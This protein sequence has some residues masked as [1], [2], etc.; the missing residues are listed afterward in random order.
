MHV[1]SLKVHLCNIRGLHSNLDPVHYHLETEKPHL[2]FLT[3]TQIRCPSD[4]A[5]LNYPNY[6]LEHNFRQR[7]GVCVY[8]RNDICCRRLRNL[9]DPDFSVL[10]ILVDTGIEQILYCG[11]YRSHSG[12][13]DTTRLFEHLGG[14]AELA[15]QRYPSAQLVFLGDFNA[16]HQDW[17][18]P[19][20]KTDHA[21]REARTFSLSLG[22]SQL[23]HCAT[24][25]PDVASQTSNCLD[26]LMTTNPDRYQVTVTA[27]IGTSDHCLVKSVS[28]Y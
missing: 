13:Q 12:D 24:R 2:L 11:V 1:L 9:E 26:L 27:P 6:T 20:Q 19:F 8:A 10:W 18:F 23:V 21:G 16:H 3:E 22:L 25:V 17:L 7:A 5:Y 15:Q 4:V 14:V 28:T